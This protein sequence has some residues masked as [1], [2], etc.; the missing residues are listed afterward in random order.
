MAN[1]TN[2]NCF[3]LCNHCL[4]INLDITHDTII[5]LNNYV[6]FITLLATIRIHSL[7]CSVIVFSILLFLQQQE[8]KEKLEH[9]FGKVFL[10]RVT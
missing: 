4:S 5:N 3:F 10:L 6:W 7:L 8:N 2:L 9:W 1:D